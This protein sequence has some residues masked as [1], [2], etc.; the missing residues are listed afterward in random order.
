MRTNFKPMHV[1]IYKTSISSKLHIRKIARSLDL[2]VS[3][4]GWSVDIEDVDNVLRIESQE[5]EEPLFKEL[6]KNAGYECEV[7]K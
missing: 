5:T 2:H 7:L 4:S 3:I 6:V 1:W